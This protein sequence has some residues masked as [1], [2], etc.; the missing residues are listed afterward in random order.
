[1]GPQNYACILLLPLV[2]GL[3]GYD[4]GGHGLNITTLSLQ[5][6]GDCE[7]A[8]VHTVTEETYVQLLQLTN[9]DRTKIQ[10]CKVEMHHPLLR[11]AL[12]YLRC[13]Q[14][15]QNILTHPVEFWLVSRSYIVSIYV[16]PLSVVGSGPTISINTLSNAMPGVSVS[17]MGC[18][19][20]TRTNFFNWQFRHSCI[21]LCISDFIPDQK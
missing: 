9:Y 2:S 4:C 7:L 14:R 17:T 16:F 1:M 10:Q 3:V 20:F 8:G 11:H 12:A 15:S 5:D 6:V 21:Y 19:V 18:R 13:A